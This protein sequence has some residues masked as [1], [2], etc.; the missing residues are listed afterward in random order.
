MPNQII[1]KFS[2]QAKMPLQEIFR[3]VT[4]VKS[5]PSNNFFPLL[6]KGR[7]QHGFKDTFYTHINAQKGSRK[8]AP[9]SKLYDNESDALPLNH[10]VCN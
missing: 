10:L 8:W 5:N 2:F 6:W 9:N 1:I 7:N 4:E 3:L